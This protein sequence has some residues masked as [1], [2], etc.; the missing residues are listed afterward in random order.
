MITQRQ[1]MANRRAEMYCLIREHG[2]KITKYKDLTILIYTND[3]EGTET[4]FI[5]AYKDRGV[6][7]YFDFNHI[8]NKIF[9]S[10]VNKLKRYADRRAEYKLNK[11]LQT[12]TRKLKMMQLRISH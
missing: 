4:F 7:Y 5:K 12:W 6:K 2:G 11:Q 3:V 1:I 10:E 8:S 9:M